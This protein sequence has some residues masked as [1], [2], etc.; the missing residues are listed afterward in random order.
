MDLSDIKKAIES[1]IFISDQPV[2]VDKLSLA[3]PNVER[4]Q[5]RKCLKE[6][7]EEWDALN[8]GFLL[9]E[10][11]G[12]FQF[13]TDPRYSED[14]SNYNKKVRKFRLSRPALEV[15][16]IIAYK[17]PVT[18]VEIEAIRGVDS[19]GVINVLMERRVIEIKGRKEVIGKP[20]LY[21]TTAE[22]LEVFGLKTLNDLPTL[23]E[24]DEITQNLEPSI[25][26]VPEDNE[27]T[28]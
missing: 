3:F 20:F 6:L 23:K 15:T 1:I 25:T 9:S 11:A 28:L 8:R 27:S 19:S 5:L 17:Q 4:A 22:F 13:R 16:A 21:G 14:I 2:S 10:I 26:P 24:L 12:G 18:K 7:V